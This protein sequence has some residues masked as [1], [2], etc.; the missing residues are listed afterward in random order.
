MSQKVFILR[1]LSGAGKSTMA[2]KIRQH[3]QGNAEIVSADNFF[4][5][6]G[7]YRFQQS[8]LARAHQ[9]CY[10]NFCLALEMSENIIVDNTNSRRHEYIPYIQL[11]RSERAAIYI[12]E[13]PCP[14]EGTL[15]A[16]YLRNKHNVTR[17]VI[18]N[19]RNHWEKDYD[20]HY[21]VDGRDLHHFLTTI[22]PRA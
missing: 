2:H 11:A 6:N 19:M 21:M 3:F 16:F 17:E 5:R 12:L 22:K 7:V 20:A 9:Q 4:M 18:I 1:G 13:I 8:L 10:D 14:D 15:Q